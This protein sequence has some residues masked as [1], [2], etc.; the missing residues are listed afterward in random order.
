VPHAGICAGGAGNTR[1]PTATQRNQLFL[2]GIE[3]NNQ[4][5]KNLVSSISCF[6]LNVIVGIW[7]V[8]YLIK[9]LGLAA[10]GLVPLAVTVTSYMGLFT[11]A[12][13]ASV[14]RFMTMALDRQ[15]FTESNRVFNTAFWGTMAVLTILLGPALWLSAQARMFFNVPLGYEDQFVRLFLCAIGNF[16]LTTLSNPFGIASFCRNRF[17]L[18]NTVNIAGTLVRVAAILLLFALFVPKV[19]HVGLAMLLAGIASLAFSVVVWRRLTPT[20]KLQRSAFSF[21]TLGQLAGM[22]GWMLIN[23]IGSLLY[24]GID[25]VVVN[26]MIGAAAG[27]QYGAVMTWSVMLRN[28]AG[29]VAVV[30]GPTIITL[31]S[32]KDAMGLVAYSRR[33]VKFVGLMMA[34]PIGLICGF[35]QPLLHLWLGPAYEPLAPLMILLSMHLCVNLAVLPLF[36]IQVATNHV[37]LPGILTCVMGVGNLGLALLLAGPVGWGVYG[38]AAAGAIMLTAK[39]IVFTPLYAAH[40]LRLDYPVF[41]REILPVVGVT[42]GLAA[43]GWWL[44][45]NYQIH[46][47][48]RLCLAATGLACVFTVVTY[49]L[50]L[51]DEERHHAMSL[52]LLREAVTK[53]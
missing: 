23:Q 44:A 53:P 16:Y 7:I 38:V 36:N 50:L 30:F 6:A 33:A 15:D 26:K 51:T 24:L 17:D 1:I 12:L 20:L 43:V 49:R 2:K 25:L 19:W 31:Y 52:L 21:Q 48:V 39:N 37:R 10:Y 13:N 42:L 14:G 9:H 34:L 3:L 5:T 45:Q 46:S 4:F 29:V 27:G 22:G 28:L 40:V 8:P 47:W 32:Q 35:A 11:V 41:Y 18:A